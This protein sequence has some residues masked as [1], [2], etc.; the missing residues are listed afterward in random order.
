M[1][2]ELDTANLSRTDVLMLAHLVAAYDV[3]TEGAAGKVGP[4]EA[5]EKGRIDKA[6]EAE[7]LNEPDHRSDYHEE[8]TAAEPVAE[9]KPKRR[10]RT[11]AEMEAA[12]AAEAAEHEDRTPRLADDEPEAAPADLPAPE[13]TKTTDAPSTTVIEKYRAEAVERA[14]AMVA[15]GDRATVVAALESVG[16]KKVS[17][18]A[19]DKLAA[20]LGALA[21]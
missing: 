12:R 19:D 14:T 3:K 20:F 21:A 16:A 9:E 17:Q 13:Q 10:R 1:K 18:I 2:I 8:P 15:D 6:A 7:D 11:K 5:Y 4:V